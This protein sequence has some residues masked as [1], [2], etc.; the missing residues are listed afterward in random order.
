MPTLPP[1]KDVPLFPEEPK[2]Q[3]EEPFDPSD[4][5]PVKASFKGGEELPKPVP[6]APALSDADFGTGEM[7]KK[8][9]EA[10]GLPEGVA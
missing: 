3:W 2:A 8:T 10:F 1:P 7:T 6:Q 9:Q 5:S 4:A